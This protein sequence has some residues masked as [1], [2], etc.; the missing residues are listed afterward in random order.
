VWGKSK[1]R[2]VQAS[3]QSVSIRGT[4]G[5]I[6]GRTD[7]GAVGAVRKRTGLSSRIM[8]SIALASFDWKTRR[9]LYRFLSVG[10]RNGLP[11]EDVMDRKAKSFEKRGRPSAAILRDVARQMRNGTSLGESLRT[12]LPPEEV[13]VVASA[14]ASGEHMPESLRGYIRTRA[15]VQRVMNAFRN[16]MSQ[17]LIYMATMYLV[18][19]SIT[20]YAAPNLASANLEHASTSVRMLIAIS[21]IAGSWVGE[22]PPIAGL[23][24]FFVVRRALSTWTGRSRIFAEKFFPF[25]YYRNMQG[26][27]WATG[28]VV[29]LDT[30]SEV[31]VLERQIDYASPWL[32]ERLRHFCRLIEN[33]KSLG[34]ALTTPKRDSWPAFDFPSPDMVDEIESYGDFSDFTTVIREVLEMW[35]EEMEDETLEKAKRFEFW[36]NI[37]MYVLIGLLIYAMQAVASL[38]NH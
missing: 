26:F 2:D 32:R 34:E 8:A 7:D 38:P 5:G 20:K 17:P 14:E 36:L 33:G 31:Q 22:V 25:S 28:Y 16:A 19:L 15:R 3:P 37:F 27:I 4:A 35:A 13:S 12:Y 11:A 21:S 30:E 1:T 29:L 23:A 24:L 18:L 9:S 6:L 10:V